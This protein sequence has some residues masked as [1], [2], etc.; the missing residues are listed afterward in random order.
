MSSSKSFSPSVFR[1]REEGVKHGPCAALGSGDALDPERRDFAAR[2]F[3]P[4]GA[5]LVL[6]ERGLVCLVEHEH[7]AL[8]LFVC[9]APHPADVLVLRLLGCVEDDARDVRS[10]R[11]TPRHPVEDAPKP[12]DG[13][14]ESRRV[15]QHELSALIGDD[16]AYGVARRLLDRRDDGNLLADK[17]VDKSRFAG[18]SPSHHADNSDFHGFSARAVHFVAVL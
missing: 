16:S 10:R 9:D 13:L 3:A 4:R 17:R 18:V 6:E 7:D 1:K 5:E 15:E 8:R 2:L 11:R 14:V 12:S